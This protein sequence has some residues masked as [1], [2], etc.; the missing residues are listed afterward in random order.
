MSIRA[1]RV[2]RRWLLW[3]G[4]GFVL[5]LAF[6]WFPRSI[7]DDTW[8]YLDIGRNLLRHGVY[9]VGSGNT[10]SPTLFRLPGY[11]IFLGVCNQL[12]GQLPHSGWLVVVYLLQTLADIGGG[13][14]LAIF[15]YRTISP[16]AGEIA[17][18]LAM[19]CPFTA[20][21]AGIAL[22]ECLS[23]FAISLGFYAAG[24]ILVAERTGSG[25]MPVPIDTRAAIWAGCAAALAMLLRPDGVLLFVT[26]AGGLF[27]YIIRSR[28]A[29]SISFALRRSFTLISIYCAVAL[30][31]IAAWTVRNWVTLRVVQPLAPRYL[32]DPGDRV[33]TGIYRWMRT[34]TVEYVSTATV[35]WQVGTGPIDPPALPARAFDSPAQQAETLALIDEYNR[36]NSVSARLDDHFAA[37]AS[38][39][40]HAH[41]CRYYV[42]LPLLRTADMML[43]PRTEE[44]N[45][46]VFWWRLGDHP[47]QNI[48][49][50]LLGLVN[51]LYIAAA[52]W[53]FLRSRMPW[54]WMLGGYIVLRCLLLGTMENPEPRYS[55][56]CFPIFI[57]AAAAAIASIRFSPL[58]N[59]VTAE[60]MTRRLAL[61]RQSSSD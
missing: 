57:V 28:A 13:L 6:I 42:W 10:L 47:G 51:F 21:E 14:L 48:A 50:I 25:D 8:D 49:A 1:S 20:A 36:T 5:R 30:A 55:L 15:A 43:R 44:F 9:S 45:L 37:L 60:A 53:A 16:R 26:L 24:R 3:I 52:A 17:L 54:P 12:F 35:F 39:R 58:T 61:V 31:P 41:P 22:T 18:A 33:N 29:Q 27:F 4:L 34:W 32:N 2:P 7:D 46:D 56:E 38:A 11:P 59:E 40:I 19:L 23:I